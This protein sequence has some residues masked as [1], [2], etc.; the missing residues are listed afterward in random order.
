LP[1]AAH[2]AGLRVVTLLGVVNAAGHET[3]GQP[4]EWWRWA[5]RMP[6]VTWRR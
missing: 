4:R 2:L 1:L 5:T 6:H 3:G